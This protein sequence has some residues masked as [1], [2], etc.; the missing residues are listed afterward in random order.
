[1]QP[2]FGVHDNFK[3]VFDH[4]ILQQNIK[5]Q[6]YL[7]KRIQ[8]FIKKYHVFIGTNHLIRTSLVSII[9]SLM[10]SLRQNV[11]QP[12]RTKVYTDI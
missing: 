6:P 9:S 4:K 8:W 11:H 12:L 10:N 7:K 1:M 3:K 5:Q 2:N